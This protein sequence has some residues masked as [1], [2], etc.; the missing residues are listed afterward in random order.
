M[1]LK[2][3]S[4]DVMVS[5]VTQCHMYVCNCIYTQ[6]IYVDEWSV[7]GNQFDWENLTSC[8]RK[9]VHIVYVN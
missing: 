3:D 8:V 9:F 1:Q 4:V 5:A 2:L 7:D 6:T